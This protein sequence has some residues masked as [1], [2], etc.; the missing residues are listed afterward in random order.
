[1]GYHPFN[2]RRTF[3]CHRATYVATGFRVRPRTVPLLLLLLL[4]VWTVTAETSPTNHPPVAEASVQE[5]PTDLWTNMSIRFSSSG[6][7]DFDGEG[8]ISFSWD[9][10]DGSNIS[11]EAYPVHVFREPGMYE[12][13][14]TVVDQKGVVDMESFVLTVRRDYGDS[15]VVIKA[16]EHGGRNTFWS[17]GPDLQ[18]VAV[19]RNGWVA[20]MCDL[21]KGDGI[22]VSVTVLGDRPV[23]VYLFRHEEFLT[24][25]H[26]PS[27]E[28]FVSRAEMAELGL[29]GELSYDLF[30]PATDRYYVVVDN[31]DLPPGTDTQGPVDY[32]ISIGSRWWSTGSPDVPNGTWSLLGVTIVPAA[33]LAAFVML[34]RRRRG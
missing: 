6:S 21:E 20:Y 18:R 16:L 19:R 26:E 2:Q 9:F 4:A 30:A 29:T 12:V 14:L 8:R 33:L 17:P 1:M 34:S 15:D 24:Y 11:R 28:W 23:D 10:G 5:E 31:R 25:M 3:I 7:Y 32:T 27:D 22:D 13:T